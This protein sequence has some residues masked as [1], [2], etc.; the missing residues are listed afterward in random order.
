MSTTIYDTG[1]DCDWCG[2]RIRIPLSEFQA[3]PNL[4]LGD[5]PKFCSLWCGFEAFHYLGL[6]P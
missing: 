2:Q 1:R 6:Q 4:L 5:G 3:A